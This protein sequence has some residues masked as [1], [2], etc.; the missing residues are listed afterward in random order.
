MAL[1]IPHPLNVIPKSCPVQALGSALL[2]LRPPGKPPFHPCVSVVRPCSRFFFGIIGTFGTASCLASNQTM[3]SSI[4]K[5]S[6]TG[7]VSR[8]AATTLRSRFKVMN[9]RGLWATIFH[10]TNRLNASKGLAHLLV[11]P[12]KR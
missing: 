10:Q 5:P 7:A 4:L 12:K 6:K 9:L 8:F 3:R 2:S 1:G 11:D